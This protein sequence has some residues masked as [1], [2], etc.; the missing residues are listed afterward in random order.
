MQKICKNKRKGLTSINS[1]KSWTSLC[2]TYEK[3]NFITVY[4]SDISPEDEV[5]DS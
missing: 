5:N 3:L 2:N 4:I 1:F